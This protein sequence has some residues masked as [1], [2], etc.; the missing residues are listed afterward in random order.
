MNGDD[1]DVG[2]GKLNVEFREIDDEEGF[3]KE[4]KYLDFPFKSTT[5]PLVR[6]GIV[7]VA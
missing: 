4:D 2:L 6:S 5:A 3:K 7:I 1:V